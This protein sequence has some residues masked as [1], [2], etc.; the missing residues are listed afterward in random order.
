M[1]TF[2]S[3]GA[4][5]SGAA[6]RGN[7]LWGALPL[8]EAVVAHEPLGLMTDVDGTIAGIAASPW[9][10]EVSPE[11][12]RLLTSLCKRLAV[13]AAVSG[14]R[15]TEVEGMVGVEG[16]LYFGNH[17][18]ESSQDG[19]S[20]T[21][22]RGVRKLRQDIAEARE[23][24]QQR[25]GGVPGLVFEDKGLAVAVHY[26]Q[27]PNPEKISGLALKEAKRLALP[28]GLAVK[29][30]KMVVEVCPKQASKGWSVA[31][32]A[33]RFRL[34]GAI[35]LGDDETDIDAFRALHSL[36]RKGFRGLA[37]AVR[38]GESPERLLDAADLSLDGVSEV[39]GFL[40]WLDR[41]L[42]GPGSSGPPSGGEASG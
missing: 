8:V 21:V 42:S 13:V 11:A 26:R 1:R 16:M 33:R 32:L 18:L 12:R 41:R 40:Q 34:S 24:L 15:A 25:L 39:V 17:G 7:S 29:T 3:P 6:R 22:L 20:R 27:S 31:R 19:R 14:R 5:G 2:A 28:R 4:D 37:V 10:A 35:Y 23:G 36:R 38:S 30:G 9:Q